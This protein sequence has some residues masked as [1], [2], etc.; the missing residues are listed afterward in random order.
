MV[1]HTLKERK[2]RLGTHRPNMQS[3]PTCAEPRGIQAC[4]RYAS[5][6]TRKECFLGMRARATFSDPIAQ[7]EQRKAQ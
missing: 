6:N 4:T 7:I 3:V 1:N 5:A 2:L